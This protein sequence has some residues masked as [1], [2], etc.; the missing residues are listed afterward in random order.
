MS[1]WWTWDEELPA[2]LRNRP[3]ISEVL[4][5]RMSLEGKAARVNVSSTL[6]LNMQ[7]ALVGHEQTQHQHVIQLSKPTTNITLNYNP[8]GLATAC[9]GCQRRHCRHQAVRPRAGVTARPWCA[10]HDAESCAR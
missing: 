2:F 4:D 9:A 1:R 6:A 7:Q 3:F 10:G 8:T 5:W